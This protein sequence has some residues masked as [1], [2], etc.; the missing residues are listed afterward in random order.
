MI[1]SNCKKYLHPY[2]K[3]ESSHVTE[4]LDLLL[5]IY[6]LRIAFVKRLFVLHLLNS[7]KK[8]FTA[9]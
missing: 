6:F 5:G 1:L 8:H 9:N 3:A 7:F 2:G 4:V